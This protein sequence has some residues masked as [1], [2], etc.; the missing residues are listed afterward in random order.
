VGERTSYGTGTF[1]WVDLST[2][3]AEGAKA[4]YAGLFGW[5]YEALPV[6]D[7][8]VYTICRLDGKDV[9]ALST[10]SDQERSQGIP[11]HWNSYVT[12]EEVDA[13]AARVAKLN[14]SLMMP[15]F[16]VMEAGRMALAAD[17][18]GAVFAIWQP[19]N[20][21]GAALVNVPGAL[22]WNELATSDVEA[23]K[24]FYGGL[25]GWTYEE[26]DAGDMGVY[27]VIRNG[28]RSN[29]G[30][31]PQG[32]Q[33]QGI[34]PSW[35]PYFGTEKCDESAAKATELGGRVL[36]PATQVGAGT[37]AAIADPQGAV[38]AVFEGDFD[39]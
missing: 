37:F 33:E 25:F 4:F 34:A 29:G 11:P 28:D 20:H 21:T 19:Q 35:V 2:G 22:T 7:D 10:Q 15:P 14:G 5:S 38:L 1:S 24:Q 31:R 3:D 9:A 27:V 36:M 26:L 17:P 12:V 18:T 32:P 13:V 30:I 8:A 6:G 23:A 39:D 16:D